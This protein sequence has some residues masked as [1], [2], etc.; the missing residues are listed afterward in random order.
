MAGR[1]Q[2]QKGQTT[3]T[4]NKQF[5]ETL[6]EKHSPAHYY[7]NF[8]VPQYRNF[9]EKKYLTLISTTEIFLLTGTLL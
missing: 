6:T 3:L 8:C 4:L 9:W 7:K 2:I 1:K 5:K